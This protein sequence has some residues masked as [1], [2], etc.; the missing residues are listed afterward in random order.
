[1]PAPR[2]QARD[3]NENQ[4]IKTVKDAHGMY[5]EYI[6][7]KGGELGGYIP[8]IYNDLCIIRQPAQQMMG[9]DLFVVYGDLFVVEVKD[10]SRAPKSGNIYKMLTENEKETRRRYLA[11]GGDYHISLFPNDLLFI[12][13]LPLLENAPLSSPLVYPDGDICICQRCLGA[14]DNL[15]L[16]ARKANTCQNCYYIH[17]GEGEIRK[18]K[19]VNYFIDDGK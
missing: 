10:P 2:V 19:V 3:G 5:K 13:G 9:F 18:P 6:R 12:L 15:T 4:I 11:A 7:F 16:G 8:K 1:M 14:F 17:R